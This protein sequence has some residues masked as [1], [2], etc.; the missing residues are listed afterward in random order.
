[1]QNLYEHQPIG[2]HKTEYKD[3][4]LWFVF[5]N[6]NIQDI[7]IR[8][9]VKDNVVLANKTIGGIVDYYIIADNSPENVLRDIH[10]LIGK[11]ILPP[12]WLLSYHHM[13]LS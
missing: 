1:M 9:K 8:N 13:G 6:T 11:P 5:L 7:Q 12:F 2:L 10:F 3:F 4:W